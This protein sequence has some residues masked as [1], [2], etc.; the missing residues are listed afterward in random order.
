[1]NVSEAFTTD[2]TPRGFVP[3]GTVAAIL[4][5]AVTVSITETLLLPELGM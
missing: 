3:V 2:A 5:G 4:G 1:V